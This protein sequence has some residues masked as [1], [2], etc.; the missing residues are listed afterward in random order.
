[1]PPDSHT[2]H[3][4]RSLGNFGE[5]AATAYLMRQ[6]Y[7]I[8]QRNWRCRSGEIDIIAQ[9]GDELV[10]VEVRTRR[11]ATFGS[12]EESLTPSKQRRL[13]TLASTYVQ[14]YLPDECPPWRIDLIAVEVDHAG[15][16]ARLNHIPYAI[17]EQ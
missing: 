12:A 9:R 17:E 10:F 5:S 16:V 3:M 7:T 2:R 13:I 1:M 4:R 14:D 6:G 11:N 8:L 15:R